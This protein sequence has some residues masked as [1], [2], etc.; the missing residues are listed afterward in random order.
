MFKCSRL[1]VGFST[2]GLIE[3]TGR[4]Q[5]LVESKCLGIGSS[6]TT[7][8]VATTSICL[9]SKTVMTIVT[10]YLVLGL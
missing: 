10:I 9:G 5:G 7:T 8:L 1:E 2:L 4:G 6:T 3:F